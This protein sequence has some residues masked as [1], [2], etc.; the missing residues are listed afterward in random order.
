MEK[1]EKIS[2]YQNPDYPDRTECEKDHTDEF[3]RKGEEIFPG[4]GVKYHTG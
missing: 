2:H 3:V 4:D 1:T